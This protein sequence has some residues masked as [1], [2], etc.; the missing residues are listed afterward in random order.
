MSKTTFAVKRDELKV[1]MERTFDAPREAVFKAYTDPEAI[2]KWWGLR[3]QTTTVDR[4]DVRVGG[5][6]RYSAGTQPAM[7]TPSTGS[8]R[9]SSGLGFSPGR[10]TTKASLVIMRCSEWRRS[11]TWAGRR[12]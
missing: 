8:S 4:M 3:S 12:E 6:W 7:N 5:A 1:V 10:L 2:P 9:P 11:R